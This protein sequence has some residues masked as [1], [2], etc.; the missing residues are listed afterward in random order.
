MER[1]QQQNIE[2]RLKDLRHEFIEKRQKL[3][4]ARINLGLK[5]VEFE[6]NATNAQMADGLDRL[7]DQVENEIAAINHALDR[8]HLGE[9]EICESCGRTISAK[10]LEALPWTASCIQCAKGEEGEVEEEDLKEEEEAISGAEEQVELPEDLQGLSDEQLKAAVIDAILRDGQVPLDDLS[11][12]CSKGLLRVE[13]ALPD[14][15]QHS[16][17]QEIIYD[18]L[19]FRDVEEIIRIDRTAWARKDRTPGIDNEE[20]DEEPDSAEGSGTETIEAVKE[21]KTIS[22]AD[23]IIPEKGGRK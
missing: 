16:H 7:D 2:K 5:E 23:E 14:K 12:T 18:V 20:E 6:E 3:E 19:G 10:R 9:Y 4:E 8:L 15:R 11:V 21:G 13:G 22:P 1:E 17:L